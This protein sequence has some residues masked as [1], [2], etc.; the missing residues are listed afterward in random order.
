MAPIAVPP[1]PGGPHIPVVAGLCAQPRV[2]GE[3]WPVYCACEPRRA[4]RAHECEATHGPIANEPGA[5]GHGCRRWCQ[6][7]WTPTRWP[8]H[9]CGQ[10]G[11]DCAWTV[12]DVPRY[13][14]GDDGRHGSCGAAHHVQD[15]H[16]A[17]GPH[18]GKEPCDGREPSPGGPGTGHAEPVCG[19]DERRYDT[20]VC[21]RSFWRQD[22]SLQSV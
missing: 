22:A 12:Q 3:W 2:Q 7:I 11:G 4:A 8:R 18:G 15:H 13:H 20:R 19:A 14:Q 17:A 16:G 1:G 5:Q 6:C 9:L 21:R 10:D